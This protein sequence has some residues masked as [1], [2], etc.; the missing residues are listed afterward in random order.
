MTE[1]NVLTVDIVELRKQIGSVNVS[2]IPTGEK[3]GLHNLLGSILDEL[4][5]NTGCII[6][7]DKWTE[8]KQGDVMSCQ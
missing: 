2:N 1:L 6:L 3:K 8:K 7:N 4:D 5:E